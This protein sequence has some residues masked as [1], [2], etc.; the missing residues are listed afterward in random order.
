MRPRPKC[1]QSAVQIAVVTML[2][3]S[4]NIR[5]QEV[6]LHWD[7]ANQNDNLGTAIAALPDV[8]GDGFPDVLVGVIAGDCA[9]K[10]DGAAYV[11]S[12]SGGSTWTTSCGTGGGLGF[13]ATI[14]EDVDG[15]GICDYIVG[16]PAYTSSLGAKAGRVCVYSG[17]GG[18][19]IYQLEGE[20]WGN[21]FG[22]S[23]A[24]TSD[25][26]GDGRGD[27]VVGA[28]NYANFSPSNIGRSYVY[29]GAN[30]SLIRF[31]EGEQPSDHFGWN[32]AWL[33]DTDADGIEDYGVMALYDPVAE[34]GAV[35]VYSGASGNQL[36]KWEGGVG[37][38]LG[39]GMAG[40]VDWDGDGFGDVLVGAPLGLG[41]DG[42]V[43][44]YSGKDGSTLAT[45]VSEEKGLRFGYSVSSVGDMDGDG[46]PEVLVG[47]PFDSEL[48]HYTGRATLLS[49]RTLRRLVHLYGSGA[50]NT[51]FG[52]RNTGGL[53]YDAD[54][55]PDVIV[56][57]PAGSSQD[58]KG[59]RV[60][61]FAGNDLF[62]Q[63]IPDNVTAADT[64][65]IDTRGGDS[66]TLS[67]LVIRDVNGTPMFLPIQITT[68]DIN[69]EMELAAT[70]PS[71]LA[72]TTI[73][74]RSYSQKSGAKHGFV[75]SGL[76]VLS[77]N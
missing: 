21:T 5:A 59:G 13:A 17:Q 46:R 71:G 20:Q 67:I 10:D 68:L 4:S 43:F 23:V 62:L 22:Y 69:G 15:D 72:G 7:G 42:Y 32:V 25:V 73:T 26:D 48:G 56:S 65:V 19:M 75:D 11:Y 24:G 3:T 28:I 16:E 14:V 37:Y 55:I 39:E 41:T 66:G 33:G 35:Y 60:T 54:G 8:T 12:G 36:H 70:T 34:Y 30:G 44:V 49:G 2:S 47:E 1:R 45:A 31:H 53:D 74:F 40:H 6:L 61:L 29:S 64:L 38:H 27:F 50:K 77:I 63:A 76:E 58:P 57:E 18:V 51:Q 52:Y 9:A